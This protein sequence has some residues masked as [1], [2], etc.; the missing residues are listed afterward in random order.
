MGG[1]SYQPTGSFLFPAKSGKY[2]KINILVC[3]LFLVFISSSFLVNA[4]ENNNYEFVITATSPANGESNVPTNLKGGTCQKQYCSLTIGLGNSDNSPKGKGYPFLVQDSLNSS[5]VQISG[6]NPPSQ[7]KIMGSSEGGSD[8]KFYHSDALFLFNSSSNHYYLEP[9]STYTVTF[10]GGVNGVKAQYSYN[11]IVAYLASD[12][13]FSFTTGSGPT[14]TDL[15]FPSPTKK[16]TPSPRS[17]KVYPPTP[18]LIPTLASKSANTPTVIKRQNNQISSSPTPQLLEGGLPSPTPV[19]TIDNQVPQ[20]ITIWQRARLMFSNLINKLFKRSNQAEIISVTPTPTALIPTQPEETPIPTSMPTIKVKPKPTISL[21][22]ISVVE[23]NILR[24]IF[25]IS[26]PDLI[27]IILNDSGKL[28][29]YEREYYQ[30]IKGW[31]E[32]NTTALEQRIFIPSLNSTK[33]CKTSNIVE[34]KNASINLDNLN[35]T[36]R[37]T[38]MFNTAKN[39]VKPTASPKSLD[40][41]IMDIQ[42][43]FNIA[44]DTLNSLVT[45]YCRGL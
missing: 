2:M 8:P 12:Y 43:D 3:L 42:K 1:A 10:K 6:P 27:A 18:T 16:I 29:N 9:N 36:K 5:T 28:E 41:Q 4:Q 38:I 17:Q 40:E 45:K 35:T 26:S 25:G 34:I 14:K 21:K 44:R 11:T 39:Q 32:I 37:N 15:D 7:I 23:E 22:P 33:I 13:S 20:N 19:P 30:Q 24:T 31:T